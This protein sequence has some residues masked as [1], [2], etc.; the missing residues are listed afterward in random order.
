MNV[1]DLHESGAGIGHTEDGF[2][3]MA[4]GALPPARVR[5]HVETVKSNYARGDVIERLPEEDGGDDEESADGEAEGDDE[6]TERRAKR[7]ERP[8]LGSRENFW[9]S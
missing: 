4:D 6:G 5:V 7:E 3:V 2:V 9:G 1:T 8:R